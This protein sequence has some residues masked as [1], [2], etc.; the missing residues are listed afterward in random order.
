MSRG[1]T[2]SSL[3]DKQGAL[4]DYNQ[5]ICLNPD[6]AKAYNNRGLLR[7]SLGDKQGAVEDLEKAVK[8]F[9]DQGDIAN[10]KQAIEALNKLKSCQWL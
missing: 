8:L 9:F 10:Y 6:C 5:A 2:H 1:F 3:G 4:T 7:N